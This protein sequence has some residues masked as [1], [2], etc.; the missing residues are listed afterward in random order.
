MATTKLNDIINPEVMGDMIEAK[1]NALNK[2]TRIAK[3]DNTLEGTP[4]DTKTVPM[5]N[6]G[7][8][9][10]DFDPENLNGDEIPVDKLTASTTTF[11]IKC[12]AKAYGILQTAVNSGLGDPIGQAVTQIAKGIA[13]KL[14][15]DLITAAYGT[16]NIVTATDVINYSDIVTAVCSFNDEENEIEKAMYIHPEQEAALLKDTNFLSA[17]KFEAGV[18]VNG[19]IGKIAGCW[20]RK[21]LK[22]KK[23]KY[24]K[25][26]TNG[27]I[28]IVSDATTEDA[29]NLHLASVAPYTDD[30]VTVG[31]KVKAPTNGAYYKDIIIKLEPD[32]PET[33]YTES[34]LPALTIFLKKDTQVDYEW[35][36]RKQEHIVTGAKY[37]GAALTNPAKIVILNS[38]E[39][40]A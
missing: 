33:E 2:I 8:D 30:T 4:G 31:D 22:V 28:T 23:I 25:D 21:S 11:T 24:V 29:T 14:D 10:E 27:T 15:T 32:S 5:W 36:P 35:L 19:A 37:Y 13:G 17:D 1:I 39:A 9:A 12:A 6:Y 34:E 18:A 3:L 20:I 16:T 26:N 40:S 7:G 38:L